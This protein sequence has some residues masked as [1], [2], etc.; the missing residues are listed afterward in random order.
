MICPTKPDGSSPDCSKA[1]HIINN[2]W[3]QPTEGN[4]DYFDNAVEALRAAG[5]IPIFAGTNFGTKCIVTKEMN[6]VLFSLIDSSN[7]FV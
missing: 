1:P 6:T 5:I 4:E 7:I 2:S 3:G